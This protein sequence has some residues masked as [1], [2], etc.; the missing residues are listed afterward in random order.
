MNLVIGSNVFLTA[1]TGYVGN[2]FT[3]DPQG[4]LQASAYRDAGRVRRG[5]HYYYTTERPDY[6]TLV[7][8]NWVRGAHELTFGGSWR[9]T[10]DDETLDYPG[11]GVDSL[12]SG[13]FGTTRSSELACLRP[14]SRR[15]SG[16]PERV[17]G[18]T[19]KAAR[20]TTQLAL[21]YDR[22][23]PRCV[24]A[25]SGQSRFRICCRQSPRRRGQMIDLGLWSPESAHVCAG[26][27]RRTL[28]GEYGMFGATSSS[29]PWQGFSA[30]ST[31][32]L[33]Y[34]ATDRNGNNIADPGARTS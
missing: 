2:G 18:D 13:D 11:N 28:S 34:A 10:R 8:G 23:Y 32:I 19:I 12:H 6:S 1:R 14:S 20:L 7:D 16:E 4:G 25:P 27:Q 33:I 24:R 26:R 9:K 17:C 21:R 22:A 15:V 29:A 3:F 5:S 30:A 31:A